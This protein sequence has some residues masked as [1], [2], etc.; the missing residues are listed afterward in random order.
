MTPRDHHTE[1]LKAAEA[2]VDCFAPC[3][4]HCSCWVDAMAPIPGPPWGWCRQ[5]DPETTSAMRAG[6]FAKWKEDM[7]E[8]LP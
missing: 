4:P 6:E 3:G 8:T 1:M 7:Q 5:D 2:L